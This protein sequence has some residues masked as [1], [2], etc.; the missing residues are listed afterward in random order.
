[1][2]T[3]IKN[4]R[5]HRLRQMCMMPCDRGAEK[6]M[7][8]LKRAMRLAD[9]AGRDRT[10]DIRNIILN[11]NATYFFCLDDSIFGFRWQRGKQWFCEKEM[12]SKASETI[13]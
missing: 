10:K 2:Q 12:E 13:A 11:A 9:K 4:E 8:I 7:K 1:M 5:I 6:I 3:I